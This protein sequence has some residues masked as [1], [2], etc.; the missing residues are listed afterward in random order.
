[1]KNQVQ[2]IAEPHTNIT[3]FAAETARSRNRRSGMSGAFVRA[4][5]RRNASSST[6]P[7][8]SG[9]SVTGAPQP[10][11]S[12]WTMPYERSASPAVTRTAPGRS[13]R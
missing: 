4:S 5:T 12:V 7:P 8:T 2:N 11:R 6:S 13:R 10:A 1:M 3:A 9:T